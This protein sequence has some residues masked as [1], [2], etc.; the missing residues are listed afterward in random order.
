MSDVFEGPGWWMASD[1]KW[2]PAE[3]HPDPGYR[4]RFV[5]PTGAVVL[6][7]TP[8]DVGQAAQTNG[9]SQNQLTD[10]FETPVVHEHG[11]IGTQ[12]IGTQ[13]IGT[14]ASVSEEPLADL[15]EVDVPE[16]PL[17]EMPAAEV[18]VD[19]AEQAVDADLRDADWIDHH[20]PQVTEPALTPT[21]QE[22]IRVGPEPQLDVEEERP[23]FAPRLPPSVT[24]APDAH[25][26]VQIELGR[27]GA[28][29]QAAA[30]VDFSARAIRD[31]GP[32]ATTALVVV[33]GEEL[34]RP[35]TLRDRIASALIFLAGI[36]MI[37]GSFLV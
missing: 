10:S 1:G 27:S 14:Q 28:T 17:A 11:H 20:V 32:A 21:E 22:P 2:Y 31:A 3:D 29:D 18:H 8:I 5:A 35:P 33:E 36:G 30:T 23:V 37:V 24:G 34:Y 9:A 4:Q 13:D 15:A 16:A 26:D 6:E 19:T 25:P 12:D 7:Q